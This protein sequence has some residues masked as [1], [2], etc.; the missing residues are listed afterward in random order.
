M[1][2]WGMLTFVLYFLVIFDN[3]HFLSGQFENRVYTLAN[4]DFITFVTPKGLGKF[5]FNNLFVCDNSRCVPYNK[6]MV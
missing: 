4:Y 1:P 6:V 2:G 3:H 5:K